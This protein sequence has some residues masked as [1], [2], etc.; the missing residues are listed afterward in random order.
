MRGLI[1]PPKPTPSK[2]VGGDVVDVSAPNPLCVEGFPGMPACIMPG[3]AP[4]AGGFEDSTEVL[5]W[6]EPKPSSP[7]HDWGYISSMDQ[8]DRQ[9]VLELRQEIASLQHDNELYGSQEHHTA[10]EANTN[11]LRRLR[12]LAIREELRRLNEHQQKIQ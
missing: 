4:W 3:S 2:P 8:F 10:S 7:P 5:D 9:R 6:I 11:E 12:L 1:S